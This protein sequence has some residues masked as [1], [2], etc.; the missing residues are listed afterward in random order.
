MTTTYFLNLIAGNIYGSK[1]NPAIPDSYYIGLSTTAPN[2]NGTNV[3]EP[4]GSGYTR[5]ELTSLGEPASG[6]VTN[7]G[8][9]DFPESTASWGTVTHFV[10]YDAS[11]EGNLLQYGPLSTPRSI[12]PATIMSVPA[13]Y[14]NLSVQNPT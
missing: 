14:L 1:T 2:V 3:T 8:A 6:V 9:I 5:M 10:I 11:A 7:T 4:S 13:N 12:E